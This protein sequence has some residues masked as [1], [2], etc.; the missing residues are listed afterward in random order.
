[1]SRIRGEERDMSRPLKAKMERRLGSIFVISVQ[2]KWN[3]R[4]YS[5]RYSISLSLHLPFVHYAN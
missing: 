4:T 5:K 1:M 3:T 2:H